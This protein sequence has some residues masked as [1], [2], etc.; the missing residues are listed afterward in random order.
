MARKRD[1]AA[2]AAKARRELQSA[3]AGLDIF[4][5]P[6]A[7]A[8]LH[9]ATVLDVEPIRAL[10]SPYADGPASNMA[11]RRVV[12]ASAF[13]V[14]AIYNHCASSNSSNVAI[15]EQ[16]YAEARELFDFSY[17]YEQIDFS[18]K[19]AD[20]GQL[21]IFASSRQPRL[22]FA[23]TE[24]SADVAET[25]LRG[26]E[27]EIVFRG[28][29]LKLDLKT[30]H[31]IFRALTEAMRSRITCQDGRCS[32]TL[33]PDEIL[34]MRRLGAEMVKTVPVEMDGAASVGGITFDQLRVAWGALFAISNTHFMAHNLC[35]GGVAA[36]WPIDTTVL[37][38]PRREFIDLIAQISE[39]PED[40]VDTIVGWH[41]YDAR[42]SNRCAPLQPFLPLDD[43]AVCLPMLLVNGNNLERNFFKLLHRHAAL[44][45]YAS[46]VECRKEPVA[47][48]EIMSMFPSP[49][50]RVCPRVEIRGVTDADVVV[51]EVES[52]FLLVVQHKWLAAPETVEESWGNDAKLLEGVRQAVE[53]RDIFRAR[54]EL[55]RRALCLGD[56]QLIHRVEAVTVC[57]GFEHTGFVGPTDVPVITEVSFRALYEESGNLKT[58]WDAL[59]LRPDLHRATRTVRDCSMVLKLAGFDLVMPGLEY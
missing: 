31:H 32:Y 52:G 26:R 40:V 1:A 54:P 2:L 20:R 21:Q 17:A 12:E 58:L 8:V 3:F 59:N 47:L 5:R 13:A 36:K 22:T 50:Y 39:L 41:V 51:Y 24:K 35:S 33:G 56:S 7:A 55:P 37:R 34:L 46:S 18:F 25:A 38:K 14:P 10:L 48:R 27:L 19:L 16:I 23:Y 9:F 29:R 4:K 30:Q 15:N 45:R 6:R 28:E 43:D 53:A 57:R 11:H 49:A 44:R 42:I